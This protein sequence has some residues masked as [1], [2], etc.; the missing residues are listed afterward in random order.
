M[1]F[2]AFYEA[3]EPQVDYRGRELLD[4]H[5]DPLR[6]YYLRGREQD[7]D[8]IRRMMTNFCLQLEDM[9]NTVGSWALLQEHYWPGQKKLEHIG[10]D[11]KQYTL[12]EI[13]KDMHSQLTSKRNG[14]KL[15]DITR[16]F[17]NRYNYILCHMALKAGMDDEWYDRHIID[18]QEPA[19][20]GTKFKSLFVAA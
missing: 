15:K 3:Q 6:T 17:I 4:R 5:G 13:I 11:P 18:I 7:L 2:R 8:K 20:M 16:S 12:E 10:N 14:Y 19:E 9:K 1:R